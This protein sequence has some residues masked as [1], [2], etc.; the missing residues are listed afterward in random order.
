MSQIF[1][2]IDYYI[3]VSMWIIGLFNIYIIFDKKI[4]RFFVIN[5][6]KEKSINLNLELLDKFETS[7]NIKIVLF[8][9]IYLIFSIL[10]KQTIGN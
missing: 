3:T 10:I 6:Q 9:V 7:I 8:C 5:I 4:K 2:A 1:Q